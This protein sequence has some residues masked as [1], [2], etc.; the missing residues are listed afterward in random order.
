MADAKSPLSNNDLNTSDMEKTYVIPAVKV[1]YATPAN[2]LCESFKS[3]VD[4]TPGGGSDG[5]ART[6]EWNIWGDE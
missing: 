1:E 4:L 6:Q 3:N 2:L 5:D